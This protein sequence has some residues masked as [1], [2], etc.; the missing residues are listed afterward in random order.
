VLESGEA[1]L[2]NDPTSTAGLDPSQSLVRAADYAILC[3]PIG[4]GKDVVGALYLA[5]DGDRHPL[6]EPELRL[7]TVVGRTLALAVDLRRQSERMAAEND[8]LRAAQV[9]AS[10]FSGKSPAFANVV[11][12]A[13]RAA[14][15]DATVLVRGRDRH[16]QGSPRA[17]SASLE[18][19]RQQAVHRD[20]LRSAGAEPRRER[21][22]RARKGLIHRRHRT[23]HRQVRARR[24]RAR[25]S[26]T[27]S[28]SCPRTR[29]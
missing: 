27:K 20:Q 2:A 11:E 1:I 10:D 23:P 26:S 29:R 7:A 28:A 13:K 3:V 22:L 25:C 17:Q 4:R 6:T 21:T 18:R 8:A 12:M 16:R 24:R 9:A 15:S 19:A 14:R 5:S